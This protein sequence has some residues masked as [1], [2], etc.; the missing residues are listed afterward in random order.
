LAN[1][2]ERA[3]EEPGT[4][5]GAFIFCTSIRSNIEVRRSLH[6]RKQAKSKTSSPKALEECPMLSLHCA[7][8]FCVPVRTVLC[9]AVLVVFVNPGSPHAAPPTFQPISAYASGGI[10]QYTAV[11]DVNRDGKLDVVVSNQNGVIAVV[12]GNGD[13]SFQPPKT[14][15]ALPAGMYPILGV[16][17]NGDG[18]TDVVVLETAKSSVLVYLGRGDGTFE[19]AKTVF[20][21]NS[22]LYMVVGDVN[23]DD[24][25]DLILNATIP[26]KGSNFPSSLGFTY[27][28]GD[29]NGSFKKPVTIQSTY[30]TGRGP[31]TVGDVNNDGHLDVIT[32]DDDGNAQVFL[33][34]GHGRFNEQVSFD[35]G[36]GGMGGESQLLLADLYGHGKLDLVVGNYG[37]SNYPGPLVVMEGNGDGTFGNTTYFSA[38]YFPTY[39]SAADMNGDGRLDLVVANSVSSSITVLINHG[40]GNFTSSVNNYATLYLEWGFNS[41]GV[42]LL[43]V[44]DFN[45]DGKP[46]VEVA[47]VSGVDV[48]LNLGKGV[49]RAP[50]SVETGQLTA[51]MFT[52]DFNGD[53]HPDIAVGTLGPDGIYAAVDVLAGHGDGTLTLTPYQFVGDIWIGTPMGGDFNGDGR[54]DISAFG[55]GTGGII[56]SYNLGNFTS[57]N[58]PVL[59]LPNQPYY[60]CAGDFNRDGY[61][62]Y[63][64]L[65]GNEVDIYLNKHDGTYRGAITYKLGPIHGS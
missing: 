59:N 52:A 54:I 61:S 2:A 58:G 41:N 42:G 15:A 28:L 3:V 38:G 27:L 8:S 25:P 29:G 34:N 35:D 57:K 40:S 53:G 10:A 30:G 62:D 55:Q 47:T 51:Q 33:G 11:A 50:A 18:D 22:P 16:D 56:Q 26:V 46:D 21:G 39:V 37:S 23:G 24:K 19:A 32:C 4:S 31:L 7:T 20:V 45:N 64:V 17:L 44:A 43:A 13:G 60:T 9:A 48:L 36:A 12:F 63:A 49:L 1:N 14:I 5:A 6:E 65:D